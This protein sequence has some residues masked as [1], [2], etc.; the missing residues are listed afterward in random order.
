METPKGWNVSYQFILM[1][2]RKNHI[3]E[4][5]K[6]KTMFKFQ[7]CSF[8]RKR[9]YG[10]IFRL[11]GNSTFIL[12]SFV[13]HAVHKTLYDPEKSS[14]EDTHFILEPGIFHRYL[15]LIFQLNFDQKALFQQMFLL[16]KSIIFRGLGLFG[17]VITLPQPSQPKHSKLT[18]SRHPADTGHWLDHTWGFV[19]VS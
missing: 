10:L 12:L 11:F 6:V 19:L 17:V 16:Q 2:G 1:F 4:S 14:L 9:R 8:K 13:L 15:E 5:P 3:N 7:I 18:R